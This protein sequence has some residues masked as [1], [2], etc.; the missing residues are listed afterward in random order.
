MISGN[1]VSDWMRFPIVIREPDCDKGIGTGMI[2]ILYMVGNHDWLFRGLWVVL[3]QQAQV[4]GHLLDD[5]LTLK[6]E[7]KVHRLDGLAHMNV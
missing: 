3:S 2:P 5:S 7:D 6:R 4:G 1:P